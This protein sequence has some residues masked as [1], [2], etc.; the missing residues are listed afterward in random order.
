MAAANNV[1]VLNCAS[2][3]LSGVLLPADQEPVAL[4]HA[5]VEGGK[6]MTLALSASEVRK[7]ID[8]VRRC[9][10]LTSEEVDAGSAQPVPGNKKSR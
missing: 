2:L 6:P 8:A 5:G 4:L 1:P 3:S 7:L 10:L 9:G